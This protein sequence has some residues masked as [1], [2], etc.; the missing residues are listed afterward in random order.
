MLISCIIFKKLIMIIYLPSQNVEIYFLF[1]NMEMKL[2]VSLCGYENCWI[3]ILYQALRFHI[4]FSWQP[5]EVVLFSLL[6]TWWSQ[7]LGI[8][9][10]RKLVQDQVSL[11]AHCS[12][13]RVKCRGTNPLAVY[14]D[15]AQWVLWGACC[16]CSTHRSVVVMSHIP[17]E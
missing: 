11:N 5:S 17:G 2:S 8:K 7:G 10:N 13:K 12:S 6:C 9:T 3:F 16:V 1:C 15:P 4:S 14:S